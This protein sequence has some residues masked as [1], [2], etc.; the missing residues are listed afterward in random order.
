MTGDIDRARDALQAIPPDL[1]RDEWV[2]AGMAAQA[3]VPPIS[4]ADARVATLATAHHDSTGSCAARTLAM[5]VRRPRTSASMRVKLWITG[6][7]PSASEARS[8][9]FE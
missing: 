8:A 7:L 2:R 5:V 3:A 1:P 6:T 9:R 4:V